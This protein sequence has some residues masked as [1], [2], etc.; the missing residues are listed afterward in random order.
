[1]GVSEVIASLCAGHAVTALVRPR[2]YGWSGQRGAIFTSAHP[3]EQ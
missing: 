2:G 3:E 1:M